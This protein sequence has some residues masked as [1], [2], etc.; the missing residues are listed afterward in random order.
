MS[1]VQLESVAAQDV[2]LQFSEIL[3]SAYK[4]GSQV[5]CLKC[6][7]YKNFGNC[8]TYMINTKSAG[9]ITPDYYM[10]HD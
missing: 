1:L 8:C 4:S 7:V 9:L 10:I 5:I 2:L 6:D 3:A